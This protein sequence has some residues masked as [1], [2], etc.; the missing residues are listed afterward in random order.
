MRL[1]GS[2]MPPPCSTPS[3]GHLEKGCS[4]TGPEPGELPKL[5]GLSSPPS[6]SSSPAQDTHHQEPSTPHSL[7]SAR[8]PKSLTPNSAH[9]PDAPI[10]AEP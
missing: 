10:P 5:R 9:Q 3:L 6:T 4:K 7:S 1:E 8:A 2:G